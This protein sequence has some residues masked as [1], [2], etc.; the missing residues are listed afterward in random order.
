MTQHLRETTEHR[1]TLVLALFFDFKETALQSVENLL[2][3]LLKQ[4]IQQQAGGIHSQKLN[5]IFQDSRRE[6]S[7][8]RQDLLEILKEEFDRRTRVYLVLDGWEG[9]SPKFRSEFD[10]VIGNLSGDGSRVSTLI[11]SRTSEDDSTTK[12]VQCRACG[13]TNLKIYYYCKICAEMEFCEADIAKGYSCGRP[14]HKMITED[15]VYMHVKPQDSQ[16]RSYVQWEM[17]RAMTDPTSRRI[18]YRKGTK[19]LSTTPLDRTLDDKPS[20]KKLISDVIVK[21]SRGNFQSA[22]LYIASIKLMPTAKDIEESLKDL[23]EGLPE[24][25][26]TMMKRFSELKPS[27]K[28]KKLIMSLYWIAKSQQP[29]TFPALQHAIAIEPSTTEIDDGNLISEQGLVL[30]SSGVVIVGNDTTVR[31]HLTMHEWLDKNSGEWFAGQ[32]SQMALR[33]LTY[34]NFEEFRQPCASDSEFDNRLTKMPLLEYASQHW[35]EHVAPCCADPNV[36]AELLK[37]LTRQGNIES[38]LQVAYEASSKLFIDFDIRK[39]ANGLHLA[40]FYGWEDVVVNLIQDEGIDVN[41]T[42]P[43]YGQT[44]LMYAARN[45][46]VKVV[47]TLLGNGAKVDVWSFRGGHTLFDA[48]LHN[49]NGEQAHVEIT[50]I[51][52]RQSDSNVNLR[53]EGEANKTLLMLASYYGND[54]LVRYILAH[55]PDV[56]VNAQDKR[57]YTA[58]ALAVEQEQQAVVELLLKDSRVR[59]DLRQEQGETALE[60]AVKTKKGKLVDLLLADRSEIFENSDEVSSA[61]FK[62]VEQ[63]KSSMV[64]ALLDRKLSVKCLDKR[65]R[66]LLHAAAF[67]GNEN[68]M[69]LLLDFDLDKNARASD[70]ATALHEASREGNLGAVKTLLKAEADK[71]LEDNF[72]RIPLVVARQNAWKTT[73]YRIMSELDSSAAPDQKPLE[74]IVSHVASLPTWSLAHIGLFDHVQARLASKSQ[75]NLM[76]R[77]PDT[78]NSALHFAALHPRKKLLEVLLQANFDQSALNFKKQNPLHIAIERGDLLTV[79]LLLRYPPYPLEAEDE[80]RRRPLKLA[81]ERGYFAIAVALV[82]VGAVLDSRDRTYIDPTFLE[83]VKLGKAQV[84]ET[85]IRHG[86]DHLR[87]GQD[88][89]SARQIAKA[90]E[91]VEMLRVLDRNKSFFVAAVPMRNG[92]L[93][94]DESGGDEEREEVEEWATP[95][96][97]PVEVKFHRPE[98][99]KPMFVARPH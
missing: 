39:G 70:G 91:D 89:V 18:N 60:L 12:I 35:A 46:Y 71:N 40:A 38:C 85:L 48:Y 51:L 45:G 13:K 52:L 58:L 74:Q 73:H 20:L 10:K 67:Q 57:G 9:I 36:K 5:R 33:L 34:L 23:P 8:H 15:Q 30:D 27:G 81:H 99:S 72:S 84:A 32:E 49:H 2:G 17:G 59:V 50:K 7:P 95:P 31:M 25:Y 97:S 75:W 22:K 68:I 80:Y 19:A 92:A 79:E 64:S 21:K 77:C 94:E 24:I 98:M 82:E 83:A 62:A 65:G 11:F 42:D 28:A 6:T 76:D 93:C 87:T 61:L 86:A 14:G 55:H 29:L 66:T 69:Q 26:M 44:A 53:Y 1:Q 63:G 3:S 78:G 56:D 96:A 16:I 41:S 90:N 47:E 4:A 88:G 37:F 43:K 54:D